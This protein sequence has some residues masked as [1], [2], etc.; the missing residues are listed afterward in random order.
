MADLPIIFS[1]PMVRALL[2]GRK[3]QTRR[4]QHKDVSM[5][6]SIDNSTGRPI[7]IDATAWDRR[8][9]VRTRYAV[10]DR[11]Y[12][13]EAVTWV[14]AWGWRYRADNDDLTEQ[15]AAGEVYKLTPSIHMPRRASRITLTITDVRVQRLQDCSEADALAEGATWHDGMGVGHSGWRHD[16]TDG[17]VFATA[18]DSFERLWG[19]LHPAIV[20]RSPGAS[21]A[22]PGAWSQNPWVAAYTFTVARGNID[23]LGAR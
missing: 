19:R 5:A 6:G 20:M 22:N 16:R 14:S 15:R 9:P 21:M 17:F 7:A 8:W 23:Q 4:V 2:D 10:G 18:R 3:T 11:L 1:A 13:R 12:V